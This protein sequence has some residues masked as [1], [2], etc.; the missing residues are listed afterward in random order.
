MIDN[1]FMKESRGFKIQS[2]GKM[3]FVTGKWQLDAS[4]LLVAFLFSDFVLAISQVFAFP[5]V[6]K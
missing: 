5:V 1:K 3:V 6:P 2:I 4:K